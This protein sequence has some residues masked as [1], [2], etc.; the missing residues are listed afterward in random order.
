MYMNSIVMH[1]DNF[2]FQPSGKGKY[3][4]DFGCEQLG[5]YLRI[6]QVYMNLN[7]SGV[8]IIHFVLVL[9]SVQSLSDHL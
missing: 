7:D 3:V 5:E 2:L 6:E 9:L 4:F 8:C 1:L